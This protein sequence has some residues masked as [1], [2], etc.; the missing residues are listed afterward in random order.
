MAKTLIRAEQEIFD[1]LADLCASPGYAHAVA[2]LCF[3]DNMIRYSG[4]MKAEDMQHLFSKSRLIRTET[5]TLIGLML[6]NP[7]D[8]TLPAP[9]VLE[10]YIEATEALLEEIHHAMSAS[11]WQDIDPTKIAEAGFNPFTSGAALREPIFYGGESAYSFQYRDFAPAKYANDDPW[12]ITNKG[13][14]IQD[15]RD[16]VLAV[17]RLQD[18]KAISVMRTMQG[19]PQ[20]TWTFLPGYAFSVQEVAECGHIDQAIVDVVLSA[21]SV[22]PDAHNEQFNALHDFNVANASPLIRMPD[23]TFLLF[24][25]YS[26]V[27]AL[28]EAPFYWMGTDKGYVSTAMRNRGVFTEQFAVER[29]RQ[30][31][32]AENVLANIDICESKDTKLAEIDALALFGNRAVVLQAKSK[33]LTLEARR[34][35]DLQIKDDFRKS[36][37]D[38]S[39]QAYRCAKLIEEGKCTFK[40][41]AGNAVTL[42][43][44]LKRIY[45]I[46]LISDHYPALSFQARQF[47]KFVATDTISPPFVMDVFALDAMTEMLSSSLHFLSYLDRRTGYTDKL[48]ASHEL[49]ILSYHLKQ[50]LW[51]DDKHDMVILDDDISAD[52]DLAMLVRREGIPGKSTPEGI[53]TRFRAT[54]L[55]RMVKAIEAR[56]DP[57]TIDLGFTLL[58]LGEDTVLDVSAGIERLAKQGIAD[59]KNH[60]VTVGL[61]SG[62]TGLT[63]HCNDDPIEVAG[64]ALQ[65]HCHARKYTEHAQ[66]WFGVC[67]RPRDQALRFGINLDFPWEQDDTMDALTKSIGKPGNLRALLREGVKA[68]TKVGRNDPCPCGSG[69][70]YKKCCLG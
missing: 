19:T 7:I 10:K 42:P 3:R 36:I 44:S 15:A 22:P 40:D 11:F 21:F 54:A 26:L 37:Q 14:S 55:G 47:L 17:S 34:G 68:R 8:Y 35:N 28:Y 64:P 9:P 53:L 16:V 31:F 51:V 18:Q 66:T 30:V 4:E 23:G 2:Y 65:R 38:S 70:K 27:E 12:L 50:N 56:P 49:T 59:G 41:A 39:D 52:L 24:H 6:K 57:A 5:S 29:L 20:E 1:E 48:M 32:G 58:T 43:A 60:D 69:K 63:I 13:F 62:G 67:V 61:S 25:I 46:C 33:R 45:V